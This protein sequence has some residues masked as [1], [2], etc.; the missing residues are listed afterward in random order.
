MSRPWR[1][2][3]AAL[4]TGGVLWLIIASLVLA[5]P[6]WSLALAA[7]AVGL[8]VLWLAAVLRQQP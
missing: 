3:I 8:G 4:I 7:A 6:P 1:A 5:G 2:L